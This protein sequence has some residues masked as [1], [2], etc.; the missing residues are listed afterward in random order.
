M[1][2]SGIRSVYFLGIGGI[3]MSSLS[4]YFRQLGARISGYD[5]TPT[6]LTNALINEGMEIHFEEDPG[7]IPNTIDLVVWTPAVPKDNLEYAF[8]T[9]KG[10]PVRKRAEILGEIS[11]PFRT[12]AVAG[13]HG[14][15]TTT[16]LLAH[17]FHS[18]GMGFLAFLGGISKNYGTNFIQS[19]VPSNII[20][21]EAN[22]HQPAMYCIVEADEYDRSFLQLAPD[23]AIITAADPDHLDIY[24][25]HDQLK[26]SFEAF[27]GKIRQGG[28]LI[29]KRE[30]IS[31]RCIIFSLRHFPI[32]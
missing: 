5:R 24:N 11:R 22:Q 14:K 13:T 20:D 21:G 19:A 12:I 17:L 1:D 8:L 32:H 30:L 31:S 25:H 9:R 2:L 3:G 18:A 29:L 26:S 28:S 7:S 15:T 4:R 23:I 16:T 27:T 6:P 10:F